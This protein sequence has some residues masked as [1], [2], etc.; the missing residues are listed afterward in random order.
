[1]Q[2]SLGMKATEE[3]ARA[4]DMHHVDVERV[5]GA[6]TFVRTRIEGVAAP[7]VVGAQ[8][9]ESPN[10]LA[11]CQIEGEEAV[12]AGRGEQDRLIPAA[13]FVAVLQVPVAV[14]RLDLEVAAVPEEF[15]ARRDVDGV[16]VEFD[17]AQTAVCAAAFEVDSARIPVDVLDDFAFV[18][19]DRI[20]PAVALALL[21]ASHDRR[22]DELG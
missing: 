1:M 10:V 2:Q 12:E 3:D 14:R 15:V 5:D 22:C 11:P 13:D 9:V 20:H 16:L 19:I 8:Q 21:G 6:R 18:E 17:A 4:V 7:L